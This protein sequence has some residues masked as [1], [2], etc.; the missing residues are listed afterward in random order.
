ML[1]ESITLLVFLD[2]MYLI[3]IENMLNLFPIIHSESYISLVLK[4]LSF[5]K[6]LH[7]RRVVVIQKFNQLIRH[8]THNPI[9][10]E[11]MYLTSVSLSNLSV[12]RHS[13]CILFSYA[14]S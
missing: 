5:S 11:S 7:I 12:S 3:A 9:V 10:V 1:T 4:R 13:M 14:K 8:T 2:N 6:N